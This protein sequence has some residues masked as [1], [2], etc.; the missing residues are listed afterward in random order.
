[1]SN[2]YAL[3][4]VTAVLRSRL[5]HHL[6]AAGLSGAIGDFTV[7][8][9]PPDRIPLGAAEPTQL[10]V[11][12]YQVSPNQAWRNVNLP[13]TDSAG[14]SV[15]APPLGLDLHYLLTAY[16][17]NMFVGEIVLGHALRALN[18]EP[19]L[20]R[21]VIRAAL[22]PA[23]PDRRCP[24][25]C[26]VPGWPIRSSV[27]LSPTVMS[28]RS[29]RSCGR[30]CR[31]TTGSP[32][33]TRPAWCSSRA[34]GRAVARSRF[35][36]GGGRGGRAATG[37]GRGGAGA[38]RVPDRRG[39]QHRAAWSWAER[40][41]CR[42][43]LG[44]ADHTPAVGNVTPGRITVELA[45]VGVPLRAGWVTAQVRTRGCWVTRPPRTRGSRRIRWRSCCCRRRRA[46]DRRG[47]ETSTGCSCPPDNRHHGH[48]EG[49]RAATTNPAAQRVRCTRGAAG[50]CGRA[51]T[52]GRAVRD[53]DVDT[54]QVVFAF[55][56]VPS[57]NYLVRL[58]V[59]GA[60]S[61]L[62][63][64]GSGRYGSRGDAVTAGAAGAGGRGDSADG[65]EASMRWAAPAATG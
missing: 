11:F 3:A 54:G 16:G 59:D 25:C 39:Q 31:R 65:V 53:G 14:A 20:D 29:C 30:R 50:A 61:P 40:A 21:D 35:R 18:D 9:L 48:P 56:G 51:G 63:K 23:A 1:M 44:G 49:D 2:G 58:P 41:E 57:A 17:P 62:S 7:S 8:A 33:F 10:N 38:D 6:I 45:A 34:P 43:A 13:A 15:D 47:T 60:E 5:N 12:L 19:V 27:R 37:R 32:P 22:N 42:H 46:G 28:P 64:D 26:R 52:A 24:R 55:G 36:A 4:A